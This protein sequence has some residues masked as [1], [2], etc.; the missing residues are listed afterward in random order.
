MTPRWHSLLDHHTM[1]ALVGMVLLAVGLTGAASLWV[2]L[3]VAG[4]VLL[5]LSILGARR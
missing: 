4:A 3:T 1:T 2:A 5:A